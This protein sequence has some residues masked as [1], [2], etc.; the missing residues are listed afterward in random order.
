MLTVHNKTQARG[1]STHH[2]DGV[3]HERLGADQLVVAGVVDHV[4]DTRLTGA[5][6]KKNKR[7]TNIKILNIST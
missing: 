1:V 4:E 2:D 6:C 5:H 3:L 7:E